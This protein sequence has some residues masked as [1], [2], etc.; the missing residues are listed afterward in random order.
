[1]HER[2]T[3]DDNM[4]TQDASDDDNND[5]DADS[6]DDGNDNETESVETTES[7]RV[8]ARVL[9]EMHRL[10]GWFNP[11]ANEVIDRAEAEADETGNDSDDATHQSGREIANTMIELL[12]SQFAFYAKAGVIGT[13]LDFK[14]AYKQIPIEPTTFHEAYYHPDPEQ[15]E[16]WREAI[17]KEFRDMQRRGV[18]KKVRR[19]TVPQNWRCIKCK[20]VF[21]IKRDGTFRARLVACGYSQVP[22][23]DYT[24]NYAPVINDVAWRILLITMLVWNLDAII[25]DVESAFLYGDLDEEIYMDLPD[26]MTGFEDECLLLLKAIYGLVQAARQWHKKL[27]EVLKKIGFKGGIADP[28]L[29]M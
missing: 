1:L 26:R 8:H 29:M 24:E 16:K 27:I 23:V 15:Q 28:C 14:D 18:W 13:N 9:R 19:T 5:D 22:G 6:N 10:S 11:I 12:P 25:I 3:S 20:W 4:A 7:N 21:K 2:S 17:K